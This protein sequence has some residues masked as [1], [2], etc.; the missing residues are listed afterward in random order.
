MSSDDDG[1]ISEAYKA[2]KLSTNYVLVWLQSQYPLMVPANAA[3]FTSTSDILKAVSVLQ[4]RKISVPS[5]VIAYLRNAIAKRLEVAAIYQGLGTN[6]LEHAVFLES[7]VTLNPFSSLELLADE[8]DDEPNF[9]TPCALPEVPPAIQ[10]QSKPRTLPKRSNVPELLLEDDLLDVLAQ[11]VIYIYLYVLW[12]DAHRLHTMYPKFAASLA[13]RHGPISGPARFCNLGETVQFF[14]TFRQ[15]IT[16]RE[17]SE[18]HRTVD[19]AQLLPYRRPEAR[20]SAVEP[21]ESQRTKLEKKS[22]VDVLMTI[23]SMITEK[24]RASQLKD[25]LPHDSYRL[26]TC[27]PLQLATEEFLKLKDKSLPPK[28]GLVMGMDLFLSTSEGF[29]WA[30]ERLNVQSCRKLAIQLSKD[31]EVRILP[32]ITAVKAIPQQHRRRGYDTMLEG[33][34]QLHEDVA[35]YQ[36]QEPPELYHQAPW[37]AGHH[38]AEMLARAHL[39]GNRITCEWNIV[40]SVLHMYNALCR[41]HFNLPKIEL[42]EELCELFTES[43]FLGSRPDR[44]FCSH[45]RRA[46]FETSISNGTVQIV[47]K[48][49]HSI[50]RRSVHSSLIDVHLNEHHVSQTVLCKLYDLP[51]RVDP[52]YALREKMRMVKKNSFRSFT[53]KL[54]DKLLPEFQGPHPVA[55]VNYFSIFALCARILRDFCRLIQPSTYRAIRSTVDFKCLLLK[56]ATLAD[57]VLQTIFKEQGILEMGQRLQDIQLLQAAAE[58]FES[59]DN[60]ATLQQFLWKV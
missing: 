40:P 38:M 34:E 21:D 41:S 9:P 2:Y 22:V 7:F 46:N 13:N 18:F 8:S 20:I 57:T 14:D 37:T 10:S 56:G 31:M 50:R 54:K 5:S 51:I 6:D 47:M 52:S 17:A 32:V 19:I 26:D 15:L 28:T 35:A 30:D 42:M 27:T 39:I 44:N 24:T 36:R 60:T 58:A 25:S 12:R 45:Y 55:R 16:E 3:S 43:M 33:L 1:A 49:N 11:V 23:E 4:E 48:K 53:E 29:L 59:V